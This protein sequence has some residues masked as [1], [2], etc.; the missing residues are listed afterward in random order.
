MIGTRD[1]EPA[2]LDVH[3]VWRY[4]GYQVDREDIE[5][6]FE[7]PVVPAPAPAPVP[8]PAPAVVAAQA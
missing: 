7:A 2:D 1:K 3:L 6:D 4:F 5:V 8:A